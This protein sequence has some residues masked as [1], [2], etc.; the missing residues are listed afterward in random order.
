M[1]KIKILSIAMMLSVFGSVAFAAPGNGAS[2]FVNAWHGVGSDHQADTQP[3]DTAADRHNFNDATAGGSGKNP[4][5]SANG[6]N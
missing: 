4:R 5:G 6:G 1:K 2:G 3:G